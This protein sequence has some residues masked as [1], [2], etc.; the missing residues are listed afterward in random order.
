MQRHNLSLFSLFTGAV[1]AAIAITL[2]VTDGRFTSYGVRWAT[3]GIV[4]AGVFGVLLIA[5][6]V[7]V[8]T[9]ERRVESESGFAAD[10]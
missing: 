3:I 1:F 7:K 5:V 6:A 2:L 9:A 4:A 10:E 8:I